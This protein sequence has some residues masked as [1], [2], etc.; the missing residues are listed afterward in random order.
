V[1]TRA[2]CL[3][4][5]FSRGE[6]K[7]CLFV[8]VVVVVVREGVLMRERRIAFLRREAD[9][10]YMAFSGAD[11]MAGVWERYGDGLAGKSDGGKTN[12]S[13]GLH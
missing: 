2:K 4:V 7:C 6:V 13:R 5:C 9:L 11:V 12:A 1:D 3:L 8:D 10:L